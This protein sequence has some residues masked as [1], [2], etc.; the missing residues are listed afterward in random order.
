MS[1]ISAPYMKIR[2]QLLRWC[3]GMWQKSYPQQLYDNFYCGFT[4]QKTTVLDSFIE[5]YQRVP[6]IEKHVVRNDKSSNWPSLEQY[7]DIG[8][9]VDQVVYH[10]D[11]AAAGRLIYQA[12]IL[13]H[14]QRGDWLQ[15][16]LL[17]YLSSHAG[18]AGHHCPMACSA[19]VIRVLQHQQQLSQQQAWL[20]SLLQADYDQS[21]SGAQFL[22]EIQ[23]GSDVGQNGC[24]AFPTA[25]G[26]WRIEGE[27][28]FCSNA[29]AEVILMTAR[30]DHK[31]TGSK[32][33]ALFLVPKIWQG[34]HNHYQLRRLKDKLGTRTMASAEID[35][36]GAYAYP[37]E[38]IGQ[39]FKIVMQDVL[40]ISRI[41]NTFAVLG[42]GHQ[43]YCIA[44]SYAKHRHA[45][46]HEIIHYPLVQQ[47]LLQIMVQQQ[48]LL[49]SACAMTR[50]QQ[51][52]D[53]AVSSTDDTSKTIDEN[54]SLVLRVVVNLNKY[55]SA[56][57][58]VEHI[59]HAIDMLAGNGVIE[60][61]SSLP[62]L[63]RDALVCE[64]WEGTHNTLR[65]QMLRDIER[66]QIDEIFLQ[67]IEQEYQDILQHE[68]AEPIVT[69]IQTHRTT[70]QQWH[71]SD[72]SVKALNIKICVDQMAVLFLS[73]NLLR[74]VL[75]AVKQGKQ[76]KQE[77]QEKQD[78]LL[79]W[80]Y[81]LHDQGLVVLD[82]DQSFIALQQQLI[83]N[84]CK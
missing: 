81:Y 45:F 39:S 74:V 79:V 14:M 35:F 60:S 77:K 29:A 17:F 69:Y 37:I 11:Y 58:T 36:C 70:M 28:W 26:H 84:F 1:E 15:A 31:Q 49:A 12:D 55:I 66:L 72:S 52:Y 33:L 76:D 54:N 56:L 41:F 63:L 16:M 47:N 57:W 24:L 80:K 8:Q 75:H 10:P 32:G 61:F 9:R 5:H 44:L 48:A 23:G 22:T 2:K 68:Q 21:I 62:R 59:H 20:E 34:E 65:M 46:G 42:L 3:D 83:T 71:Q 30:Y 4:D 43:A 13:G 7:D 64:N 25:D 18:E 82:Q 73:V 40:H 53:R 78:K 27:K 38:P 6:A 67:Y 50:L 51:D 19:G